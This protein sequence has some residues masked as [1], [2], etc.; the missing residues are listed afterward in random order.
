VVV[1]GGGVGIGERRPARA[2]AG[3]TYDGGAN[4]NDE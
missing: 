3:G 2:A 4:I 1:E